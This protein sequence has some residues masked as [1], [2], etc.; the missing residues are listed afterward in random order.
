[1]VI[2]DSET[3]HH[4]ARRNLYGSNFL[5]YFERNHAWLKGPPGPGPPVT[6]YGTQAYRRLKFPD[7]DRESEAPCHCH[8]L[9]HLAQFPRP[10]LTLPR[11][12]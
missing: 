1:M 2:R 8:R 7:S 9:K 6:V 5:R 4:G 11:S 12:S 10:E 3:S